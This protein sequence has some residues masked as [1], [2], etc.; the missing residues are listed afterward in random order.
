MGEYYDK[1]KPHEKRAVDQ[2]LVSFNFSDTAKAK[3]SRAKN[4]TASGKRFIARPEIQAALDERRKELAQQY[5][6]SP[7]R[8]IGELSKIA[9][10]NPK[11]VLNKAGRIT[12]EELNEIDSHEFAAVKEIKPTKDGDLILKFHSKST[13]IDMLARNLG[14]FERDNQQKAGRINIVPAA[15]NKDPSSGVRPAAGADDDDGFNPDDF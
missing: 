6:V 5:E 7:E 11:T 10:F 9:F 12:P 2:Y 14:M 8:I 1:L 13:A 15:I 3:R 4:L